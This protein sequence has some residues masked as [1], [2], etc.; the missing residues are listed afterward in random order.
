M[1]NIFAIKPAPTDESRP[2]WEGCNRG[3]L[4]LQAC[5]SCS[6]VF[7]YPRFLCPRC[8]S[9]KLAWKPASGRGTVYS[10]THVEVS[11]YGPQ[12]ESQVPY[13]PVLVDLDEGA[14]MLSRLVGPD[15]DKVKIGDRLRVEF[16]EFEK[17]KLP[18]FSIER[19]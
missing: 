6:H 9:T 17:Q 14:R 19:D 2:F 1:E 8:G 11:F 15:R 13:T 4:L 3:E 16:V 10:F 5:E 18:F 12:W 7:Y